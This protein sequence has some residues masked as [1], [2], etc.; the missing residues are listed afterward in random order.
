MRRWASKVFDPTRPVPRDV[1]QDILAL[2]Q[3]APS[4]WN[5]QGWVCV[6]LQSPEKRKQLSWA[7]M[8]QRKITQAPAVAVFAALKNPHKNFERVKEVEMEAGTLKPEQVNAFKWESA[9]FAQTGGPCNIIGVLKSVISRV[10]QPFMR[11]V[12]Q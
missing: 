11:F 5:L 2:T 10:L 1:L 6:V 3:R 12:I 4:G 7:A 9:Y 8:D